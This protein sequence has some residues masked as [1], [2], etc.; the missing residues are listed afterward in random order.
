MLAD[1]VVTKAIR[2]DLPMLRGRFDGF[3]DG[4][5][6]RLKTLESS[7]RALHQ[8]Q[9]TRSV[10]LEIRIGF[11]WPSRAARYEGQEVRDP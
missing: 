8:N 1:D 4:I 5:N 6:R 10:G 11:H 2:D 7:I 9:Q 3:S